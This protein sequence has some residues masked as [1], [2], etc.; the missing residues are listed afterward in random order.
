LEKEIILKPCNHK[1]LAAAYGLST[2][3]LR[4]RLKPHQQAIGPRKGYKYDLGQLVEI[5]DKIGMPQ[6]PI[7]T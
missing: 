2:K 3:V 5:I 7:I 4:A 6:N 1:Q